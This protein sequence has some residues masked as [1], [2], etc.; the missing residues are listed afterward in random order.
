MNC[1]VCSEEK[2]RIWAHQW[3]AQPYS[4]VRQE[5]FP[6]LDLKDIGSGNERGQGLANVQTWLMG[7]Q[8]LFPPPSVDCTVNADPVNV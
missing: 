5:G 7:P 4:L 3:T 1:G 8:S 2:D 6:E